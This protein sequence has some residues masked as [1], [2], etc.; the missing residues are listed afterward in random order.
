MNEKISVIICTKN[1]VQEITKCIK[2]VLIQTLQP[3]EIVIID[4]SDTEALNLEIKRCF[5]EKRIVY[6]HSKPGYTY[7]QNIGIDASSGDILIF[8]DDDVVLDKDYIKNIIYVFDNDFGKK[9]GGV[10][11]EIIAET[12]DDNLVKRVFKLGNQILATM[13]FLNRY[14][15]GKFLASGLPKVIKSGSVDKI[16]N[17]E[18]L[19]GCDMAF[20]REVI[21]E[22]RFGDDLPG[23][24]G[25]A[26]DDIAY[27]I[28]R[29]YQNIYTPFAKVFLQ[30][31][32]STMGSKYAKMKKTMENH[33]YLFR[34]NLPQDLKHKFAFWWSV[35]GLFVMEGI[36]MVVRGDSSGVRGLVSGMREILKRNQ[37]NMG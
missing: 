30:D 6:V 7:Q 2:S 4:G 20:R 18:Y 10:S 5:N 21:R 32:P 13:F 31:V 17:I 34:K 14:G 28:S 22:F 26:D 9:V 11:G 15:D 8:L 25:G 24:I 16:T 1:R 36:T 12:Q 29:K 35:V 23:Y 27:R 3:D 37:G 19:H 33:Y